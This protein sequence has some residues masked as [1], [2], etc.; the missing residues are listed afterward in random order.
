MQV[1]SFPPI[2][3]KECT[4]LILGSMPGVESLR[5]QQYYAHPRNHF[6]PILFKLY[7]QELEQD[8]ERRKEFVLSRGIAVWDVLG[9]CEREG[10][11]DANISKP[12][13]ND[14]KTFLTLHPNIRK[15]YFNGGKAYD[16]FAS[17]AASLLQDFSLQYFR[18]PSTSPAHTIPFAEK[19]EAWKAIMMD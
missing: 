15:L 12:E 6:W 11:L 19:M 2:V 14:F 5:Q 1:S 4:K 10:S 13:L 9:T 17:K 16:L 3:N 7:G 18:L 8:Y